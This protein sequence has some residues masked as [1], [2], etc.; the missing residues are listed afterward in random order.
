MPWTM[1]FPQD[2]TWKERE[3]LYFLREIHRRVKFGSFTFDPGSVG[4]GTAL[5]TTVTGDAFTGLRAGM[6]IVVT[7]PSN[8]NAG[9]GVTAWVPADD[10]LTIRLLNVTAGALNPGSA[11][12]AFAGVMI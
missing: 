12:W 2:N 6:A 8:I 11:T 5:D 3:V 1:P 9:L 10:T 4:A 7:P